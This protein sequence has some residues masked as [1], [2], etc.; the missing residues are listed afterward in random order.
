[1]L[2]GHIL[3]L[4]QVS[5]GSPALLLVDCCASLLLGDIIDRLLFSFT[6]LLGHSLVLGIL[7]GP[8]LLVVGHVAH[9]LLD[10]VVDRLALEL[11]GGVSDCL[12]SLLLDDFA[13]LS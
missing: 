12:A 11:V 5:V 10:G 3:T 13:F 6:L 9:L 1:M 2:S 7:D 8:A 4:L